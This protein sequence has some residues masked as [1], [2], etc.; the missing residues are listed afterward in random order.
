MSLPLF[1]FS[2]LPMVLEDA[3][4][5]RELQPLVLIKRELLISLNSKENTNSIILF[6]SSLLEET[7][8]LR[9]RKIITRKPLMEITSLALG[10]QL[11]LK[12]NKKTFS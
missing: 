11:K 6:N 3:S 9:N 8:L 10:N 5:L 4:L 7:P 2:D 12:G 1:L